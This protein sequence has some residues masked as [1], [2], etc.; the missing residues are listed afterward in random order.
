MLCYILLTVYDYF[1]IIYC[2]TGLKFIKKDILKTETKN[3][4]LKAKEE[5]RKE[6]LRYMV[7][8]IDERAEQVG[9]I[10]KGGLVVQYYFV[11]IKSYVQGRLYAAIYLLIFAETRITKR[12]KKLLEPEQIKMNSIRFCCSIVVLE[13]LAVNLWL[14]LHLESNSACFKFFELLSTVIIIPVLLSWLSGIKVKK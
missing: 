7:N 12:L 8:Y 9:I 3:D 13:L 6:K 2:L 5:Q 10:K 14:L 4:S 11:H 1:F